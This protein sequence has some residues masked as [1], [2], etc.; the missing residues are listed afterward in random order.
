MF[1]ASHISLVKREDFQ[2]DLHRIFQTADKPSAVSF[3]ALKERIRD[4]PL[5][6]GT[7]KAAGKPEPFYS[8][9]SG[10]T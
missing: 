3:I 10:Q 4:C 6:G 7:K 1:R 9:G 5:F 2:K 8:F